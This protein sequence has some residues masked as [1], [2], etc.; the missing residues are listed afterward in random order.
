[1]EKKIRNKELTINQFDF[2]LKKT[3]EILTELGR[4]NYI[5]DSKIIIFGKKNPVEYKYAFDKAIEIGIE[6]NIFTKEEI[7]NHYTK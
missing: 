4:S 6:K 7:I 5:E 1:M 3:S 2:I